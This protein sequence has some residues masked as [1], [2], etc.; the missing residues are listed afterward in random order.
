MIGDARPPRQLACTHHPAR[1]EVP[2]AIAIEQGSFSL[3]KRAY[4]AQWSAARHT[5]LP[6]E[7]SPEQGSSRNLYCTGEKCSGDDPFFS[8]TREGGVHFLWDRAPQR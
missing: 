7:S 5:E 4:I 2:E 6:A 3:R 1:L 8:L